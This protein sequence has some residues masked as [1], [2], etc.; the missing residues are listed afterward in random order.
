MLLYHYTSAAL[1][2]AILASGLSK[3]HMNTWHEGIISPVVWL[4]TDAT[5]EGHGMTDGT[6]TNSDS[7]MNFLER[8]DGERPTNRRTHNKKKIRL[9]FDISEDDMV[10]LQLFTDYC[11]SIP[12]GKRYAKW[13]GVSCYVDV[14]TTSAKRIEAL[15]KSQPTKEKTWWISFMPVSAKHIVAVEVRDEKGKYHPYD[16]EKFVRPAIGDLGFFS[17]SAEALRE[18]QTIVRPLHPLGDAKALIICPKADFPPLVA[19]RGGGTDQMYKIETGKSLNDAPAYEP[20][21]SGWVGKYRAELMD[22]W[23]Q[24]EASYFNFFPEQRAAVALG[25]SLP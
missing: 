7:A 4:T 13:M 15:M 16:F 3:G 20:Q 21:L 11:A 12:D 2:D 14:S 1:F 5:G 8:L 23:R 10:Q 19:I 25:S 6:E 24:A 22:V 9:A 17:P 18:L